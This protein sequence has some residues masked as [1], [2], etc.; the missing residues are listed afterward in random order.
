[1]KNRLSRYWHQFKREKWLLLLCLVLAF[2]AW[3]GIRRNIGFEVSV[4]NIMVDVDVPEGWAVWDKSV[5]KVNILFR[6]SRE[7]IRYLNN[8]Q[9]RV[10]IPMPEPERGTEMVVRLKPGFLKNPTS[11][12]AKVVRFSPDEV[13]IKLDQEGMK[14]LPVKA[15]VKGS[16]PEGLEIERMVSTPATVHVKGAK[17]VLDAMENIHTEPIELKNR[18]SSFKESVQIELPQNSRL[19]IDPE[20]V[21]VEF[22]LEMRSSTALLEKIPVRILC[23]PGERRLIDVQPQVINVSVRGQ[24]QRLEQ[25]RTADVFAYVNCMELAESTAYELPVAVDLPSGVQL[26]KTE[27]AVVHVQIGKTN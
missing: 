17:Q 10:V 14:Q 18:Q 7:D 3:Q 9:L 6:G 19:T 24:Q 1:M 15:T 26:V 21:T 5:Q 11:A 23:A 12:N 13:V 4:S 2:L 8:E 20:W 27:P 25:I 16:L 22:T